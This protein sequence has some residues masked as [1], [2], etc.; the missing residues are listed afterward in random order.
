M[1]ELVGESWFWDQ[2]LRWSWIRFLV[3]FSASVLLLN[4]LEYKNLG[5][6][7]FCWQSRAPAVHNWQDLM[8]FRWL[9]N[10]APASLQLMYSKTDRGLFAQ[11]CHSL[12]G[13]RLTQAT[14]LV[15]RDC[16]ALR[17]CQP[18]LARRAI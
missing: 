15:T 6:K 18:R 5:R 10:I 8:P 12:N 3:Q 17:S 2:L 14:T 16:R 1:D 4:G 9:A 13:T 11:R 7:T